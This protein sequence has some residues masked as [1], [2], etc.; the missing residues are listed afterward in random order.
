[1]KRWP[2]RWHLF[3]SYLLVVVLS[4]GLGTWFASR[5]IRDF[6]L[7]TQ[8][9]NLEATARLV[10]ER[11]SGTALDS[12]SLQWVDPLCEELGNLSGHRVT[13]ILPDG[14]VIGDSHHDPRDMENHAGRP[15]INTAIDDH[16]RGSSKRFSRTLEQEMMY[17]AVPLQQDDALTAVVRTALSTDAISRALNRLLRTISLGGV[18]IVIFVALLGMW[19][20][21]LISRPLEEMKL[22]AEDFAAGN[23]GRRLP[24]YKAEELAALSESLNKMAAQLDE[25]LRTVIGQRNEHS[26]LF[27]SIS[28]GVIAVDS[29]QKIINVNTAAAEMLDLDEDAG[30]GLSLAE[31]IDN[32]S[33]RWFVSRAM[34]AD[35]IEDEIIIDQDTDPRY[36]QATGTAL[37]DAQGN[38]RGTVVVLNEVTRL[39]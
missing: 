37:L 38:R 27:A 12:S 11:L 18:A 23:L 36:L 2:I 21:R 32:D 22:Q 1:M 33:L 30:R 7:Q 3:P 8:E 19:I 31:V 16:H 15:E 39:R 14:Y 17:V 26:A 5:S 29:N 4:L 35:G 24:D 10:S 25:R 6:Y 13:I 34:D 20:S 28:D 9:S